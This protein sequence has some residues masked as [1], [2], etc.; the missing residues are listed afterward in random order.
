MSTRR[1][2]ISRCGLDEPHGRARCEIIEPRFMMLVGIMRGLG[3]GMGRGL[4][5]WRRRRSLTRGGRRGRGRWGWRIWRVKSRESKV[6][7][8]VVVYLVLIYYSPS[9]ILL[10]KLVRPIAKCYM[11]LR[12]YSKTA[13][14]PSPSPSP[15]LPRHAW[16]PGTLRKPQL[17]RRTDPS[18]QRVRC[19]Q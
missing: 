10:P 1:M 6:G 2:S 4:R 9:T 15:D 3:R 12:E 16:Q 11:Y 7:C 5:R 13:N 18:Y 19:K 17:P 8:L 14:H